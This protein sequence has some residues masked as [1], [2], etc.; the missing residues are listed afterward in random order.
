MT[1]T[2]APR[3]SAYAVLAA[4]GLLAALTL[5][6]PELVALSAP[7]ALVLAWGLIASREPAVRVA[8]HLDRERALE[9]DEV[10]LS[11]TLSSDVPVER[12]EVYLPVADGLEVVDGASLFVARLGRFEVERELVLACRRWG[13]Y[14]PGEVFLRLHDR[15]GLFSYERQADERRSL[16]VY[17][18]P[19][20]LRDL[21]PPAETQVYSGNQVSRGKSE[22]IEFADI[23][24][25]ATGDRVRQI[26]WRVSA[27]RGELHVNERHPERNTDVILFLDAFSEVRRGDRGTLELAVRAA[28][29][30]A[31]RYLQH[32]DRV[33]LVS[34]GGVLRWLLA[35]SGV[36]QAYRLLDS[37]I[38]T[39]LVFS[40]AWKD[41]DVIPVGTLPPKALVL[42]VSPLLDERSVATLLD[43]RARGFDLVVIEVSP[44][45]FVP[46]SEG[47]AE[48]LAH[49]IWR[50]RRD[51]LRARYHQLGVP[52]VEWRD[53]EPLAAA[54]EEVQAYRRHAVRL[55]A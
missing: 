35:E 50:M 6:R 10:R 5:R 48:Q 29:S 34:F 33:G 45:P 26:N 47:E 20:E 18:H 19:E 16:K 27:R 49:R 9:G 39:E 23:R 54:V 28:A 3:L 31:G 32:K 15:L 13:G 52:V 25:F 37:L 22:G 30:L 51:A 46:P 53:G 12:A 36:V 17:P 4:L 24:P 1:R 55:R 44:V 40:Y 38:E 8:V 14:V 11:V 2:A 41:V 7:F 42:A 43:L 21:L